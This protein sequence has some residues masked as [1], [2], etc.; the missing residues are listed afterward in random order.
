[1]TENGSQPGPSNNTKVRAWKIPE[2]VTE[3]K[4]FF[5]LCSYCRKYVKKICSITH[6]MFV[7][8]NGQINR[9]CEAKYKLVKKERLHL[10]AG[11]KANQKKTSTFVLL[12][13]IVGNSILC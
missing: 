5:E 7:I 3:V 4:Q 12:T 1:V 13:K 8:S 11:H 10:A 2:D 6:R 9:Q